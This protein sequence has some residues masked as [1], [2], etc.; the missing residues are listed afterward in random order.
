MHRGDL[1]RNCDAKGWLQPR[2]HMR[3]LVRARCCIHH[4]I[5]GSH[6]RRLH[7][8]IA[9]ILISDHCIV[10]STVGSSGIGRRISGSR[11]GHEVGLEACRHIPLRRPRGAIVIIKTPVWCAGARPKLLCWHAVPRGCSAL[12]T[13]RGAL[14]KFACKVL[15]FALL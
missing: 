6:R 1:C 10:L 11:D 13:I 14:T 8:G 2:R 15:A 3:L 7:T 5:G 12:G 4:R 9:V